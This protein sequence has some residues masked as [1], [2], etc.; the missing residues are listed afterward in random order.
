MRREWKGS[1]TSLLVAATSNTPA[2]SRKKA[3]F[4]GKNSG[5]RVRLIWRASASV[6]AKSVFTVTEAL[7]FGVRFLKTSRP[8]CSLPSLFSRPPET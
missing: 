5:K 6:S 1:T 4:S 3:R 2:P 8:A 7:R